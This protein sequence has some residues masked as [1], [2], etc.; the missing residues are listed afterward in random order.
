MIARI[1]GNRIMLGA[2]VGIIGGLILAVVLVLVLG[3]G[4]T[5]TPAVADAGAKGG[6]PATAVKKEPTKAGA[7]KAGAEAPRFGPTFVI[8]DRIVNLADPGGRRYIRFTIALEF[9]STAAT[10]PHAES[11]V[12]GKIART[13]LMSFDL[14]QDGD[15]QLVRFVPDE[16]ASRTLPVAAS[17]G[18]VDPE[19]EFQTRI[20][21]YVPALED[22]VVTILSSRTYQDLASID[23]K[24]LVKREI[25]DRCQRILGESETLTNVYFT[26]FVIQ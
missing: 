11:D 14:S 15:G 5:P 17:G 8:R 7:A 2:T 25:K 12:D 26:E 1:T 3:V 18:K 20:K 23:G 6:A 4:R 22:S 16:D 10:E 9:L 21:K 24:E 19:K 13:H